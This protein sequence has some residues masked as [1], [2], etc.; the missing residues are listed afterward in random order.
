MREEGEPGGKGQ[1]RVAD[2][3]VTEA[4]AGAA[5]EAEPSEVDRGGPQGQHRQRVALRVLLHVHL[6]CY[7]SRKGR[8]YSFFPFVTSPPNSITDM[9]FDHY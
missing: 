9:Y 3:A 4:A 7:E 8:L 1:C 6:H 2:E 5:G